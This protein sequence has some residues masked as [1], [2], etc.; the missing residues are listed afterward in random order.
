MAEPGL[1]RDHL[2]ELSACLP[3]QIVEELADGLDQTRQHYLSQGLDQHAAAQ[4]AI[5][6]FGEPRVIVAAF[7][8]ARPA[9]RAARRLLAAGP[10]VGACWCA[11]LISSRAWT[12]PVPAAAPVIFGATLITVICLLAA[13]AI[14]KRYRSVGLSGA[15]GCLGMAALDSAM[16]TAVTITAPVLAWPMILAV[17]ASAIRLAFTARNLRPV[18]TG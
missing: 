2:T 16:L 17:T 3:G 11:A 15:A 4:A 10:C 5:A 13:A 9:R 8:R 7:T 14:G 18:L 1:I 6:E 12:W